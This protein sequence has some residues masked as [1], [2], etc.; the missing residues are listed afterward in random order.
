MRNVCLVI[1][2]LLFANSAYAQTQAQATAALGITTN[3]RNGFN[4]TYDLVDNQG[5]AVDIAKDA[6]L[7][8]RDFC[9]DEDELA[10]GDA[11]VAAGN[12]KVAA[13]LG[14]AST[15]NTPTVNANLNWITGNAAYNAGDWA[16]A[17]NDLNTANANYAVATTGYTGVLQT[18]MEAEALYWEAE[19]HYCNG[20]MGGM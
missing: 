8:V 17:Y 14:V 2:C 19:T 15:L 9:E 10:A 1:L 11:K 18:L 12:A 13:A 20:S 6:A 4:N 7:S 3:T 16:D 5:G